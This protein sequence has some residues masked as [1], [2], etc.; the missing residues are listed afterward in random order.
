SGMG[1]VAPVDSNEIG[2]ESF[3]LACIAKP[4]G[5]DAAGTG[6]GR[7][8]FTYHRDGVAILTQHQHVIRKVLDGW[9]IEKNGTEV[10]EGGDHRGVREKLLGFLSRR[11]S[12]HAQR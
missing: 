9:V 3:H 12:G 10:M 5:V 8:E 7:G 4:P 1:L 11:A 6:D 2:G